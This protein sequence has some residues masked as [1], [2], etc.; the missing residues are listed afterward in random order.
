MSLSAAIFAAGC[1]WG[2]QTAFDALPG[3]ISTTV[4]YTGGNLPNPGYQQ[5]CSGSTN[6]AEAVK[7]IYDDSQISYNNLLDAFFA[8]HN[9]TTLNRQGPDVGTQY[10]SAIFYLTEE[11]KQA[12]RQKI[13]GLNRAGK[14]SSPIVTEVIAAKEFYPAEEYHQKY[15]AKQGKTSCHTAAPDN[16]KLTDAEWQQK[17][18]PEQYRVLRQKGTEMPFS[19]KYLHTSE[20]G[21]FRCAACN[22]PLFNSDAKFDSG[23]GWPSFDQAIPGSV[24]LTPDYSHGMTRTEVSC[25]RCGS[26]LGHVFND[27]PA[28]TGNRFCINSVS[29]DFTAD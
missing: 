19:G 29:L 28:T 3:V 27:G 21:V 14:F 16:G 11:Q 4:G 18:S 7:I 10:R 15:F 17:L 25:A 1:F 24:Q 2:V 12:A 9:P 22:N 20:D 13:D 23:S 5:V 6:H 26:H 8:I